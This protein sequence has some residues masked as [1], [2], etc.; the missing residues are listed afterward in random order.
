MKTALSVGVV[1][2][3][4]VGKSSV[5]NSL[6]RTQAVS[7]QATPCITKVM[8]EIELDKHFKLLDCPGIAISTSADNEASATLRN[9]TNVHEL[10]DAIAPGKTKIDLECHCAS[11]LL[12]I[13]NRRFSDH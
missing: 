5:I 13:I 12:F 8:Q 6:K 1:G 2:F 10:A 4:N 3:P 7:V 11:C 9:F